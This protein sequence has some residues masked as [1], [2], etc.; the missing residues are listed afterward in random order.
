MTRRADLVVAAV[1]LI[2][3]VG[4]A[5]YFVVLGVTADGA[6]RTVF[7]RAFPFVLAAL[8]L[9]VLGTM[10][11]RSV[12]R[13]RATPARTQDRGAFPDVERQ[14][15]RQAGAPRTTPTATPTA[16]PAPPPVAVPELSAEG[17]AET[18]RLLRVLGE[19]GVLART[20]DVDAIAEAVADA[21][22]PPTAGSVLGAIGEADFWHPGF[23]PEPHLA[24]LAFHDGHT[25]QF[26]DTLR[27]QVDD[28]ARL[29]GN[30]PAVHLEHAAIG[31]DGRH[32]LR[33]RLGDEV[34][35][36]EYPGHPTYLSTVL[37]AAV[38]RAAPGRLA[39]LW[40][41]QGVW[42][43]TPTVDVDRLNAEL[44]APDHERW[45]WVHEEEPVAAG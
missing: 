10:A 8:G 9:G 18:T 14:R 5:L 26:V 41:D 20:P 19:A 23:D 35:E 29:L 2:G 34:R 22:E 12:R 21:G 15:G 17:R 13:A 45:T 1:E 24:H 30:E 44:G 39:W 16:T 7:D 27:D 37:H 42:I 40:V 4:I 43:A 38:A 11:W 32:H 31:D 33:L 36:V 28:L 6:D 25:E 3:G